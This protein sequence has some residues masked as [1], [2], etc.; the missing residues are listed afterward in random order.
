MNDTASLMKR[1]ET[2]T[3]KVV[4]RWGDVP[5]GFPYETGAVIYDSHSGDTL[6]IF[7][8][9]D[10]D[11]KFPDDWY[12]SKPCEGHVLRDFIIKELGFAGQ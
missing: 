9:D 5:L 3:G 8:D 2:T 12:F 7:F 4:A 6:C 10:F 11:G 1:L